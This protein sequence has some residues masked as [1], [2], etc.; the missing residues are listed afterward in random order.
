M[1]KTFR[2]DNSIPEARLL[3]HPANLLSLGFGTGLSPY[4]P[5]TIG[6]LPAIPI[7]WAMSSLPVWVYLVVTLGLFLGGVVI[8]DYTTRE[9]KTQD[10]RAIV[11]DEI[12]GYLVTMTMAPVGWLWIVCGFFLFRFFDVVKPWPIGLIDRQVKGGLGIMLDD[13]IAGVYAFLCLQ[14]I[15]HVWQNYITV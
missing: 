13:I 15:A 4:V 10:H 2:T 11:W 6:T 1:S 14:A 5:G 9:L 7:Y 12:V 3:R 8:C